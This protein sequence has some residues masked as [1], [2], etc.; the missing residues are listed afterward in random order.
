[1]L[2]P[3]DLYDN[4]E[5]GNILGK[6]N[7]PVVARSW[8]WGDELTTKGQRGGV[9]GSEGVVLCC[10]RGGYVALCICQNS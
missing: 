5:K 3:T 1:M 7:R 4:C 9:W 2:G 10:S 6:E 8:G